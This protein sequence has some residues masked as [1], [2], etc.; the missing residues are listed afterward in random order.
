MAPR[1]TFPALAATAV[2]ALLSLGAASPA[3]AAACPGADT[4]PA[5][6]N[7]A[8]VAEATHCLLNEE[9]AA[10]GLKPTRPNAQLAQAAVGFSRRMVSERFFAHVAPDGE[11][12]ETRLVRSRYIAAAD[13]AFTI[14]E[15]LAWGQGELSTPRALVNGWMNSPGHRANVLHPGYAELGL[16]FALGT[17][18]DPSQGATVTAAYGTRPTAAA[19]S[20]GT[21]RCGSTRTARTRTAGARAAKVARRTC[22]VKPARRARA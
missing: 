9:R 22:A 20:R 21:Q 13:E 18:Q 4:V 14:G 15:N 2:A 12:L 8:Q 16:G 11:E 3:R 6:G 17:P 10:R 5:A 1:R 7:L 19:T